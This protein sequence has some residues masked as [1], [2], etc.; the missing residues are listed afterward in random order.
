MSWQIITDEKACI[1]CKACEI[2]CKV[3]NRVPVGLKLGVHLSQGPDVCDGK[4]TLRVLYMPC[5]HCA[6]PPCLPVCP[7]GALRRRADGIVY[8]EESACTG[9][10][11]CRMA[12]PWQVPQYDAAAQKMRKCDLCRSRLDEGLLPACVTGC[13]TK[14]LSLVHSADEETAHAHRG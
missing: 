13:T 5:Q 10:R 12:C 14:A 2:H 9:C 11:A 7:T 1:N 4:P 6:E 3:W 8:I